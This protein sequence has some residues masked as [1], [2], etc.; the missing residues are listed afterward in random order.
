[1][2]IGTELHH[3]DS[4]TSTN[5]YAKSILG[6]APEGTVVLAD[7]QTDGK[8][9]FGKEWFSPTGGI[10][11]SVILQPKV[12]SLL[13]IAT[14]VAICETLSTNGVLA[15]IKW[16]NDILINRRKIGGILTEVVDEFVVLG[17]GLNLTVRKFP[18]ELSLIASSV[19]LETK[20][21][22]NKKMVFELLCKQLDDYYTVLQHGKASDILAKWRHYTVI[23]GQQVTIEMVDK[24]ISGKVLDID[25]EGG[26]VIMPSD[27]KICRVI[28]GI[29]HLQQTS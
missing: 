12:I 15:G 29:C 17:I 11:M 10:W 24:K 28:S 1:M 23:L 4:V 7:E 13:P 22:L 27:G 20:K 26:L 2:L 14:G 19:A 21:Y 9:R 25:R 5:D 8:G 18:P 16:P 3:F 6:E